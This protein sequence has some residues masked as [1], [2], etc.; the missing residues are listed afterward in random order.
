MLDKP[1]KL[2]NKST[3]KR[4]NDEMIATKPEKA[5]TP[6]SL[7]RKAEKPL[8]EDNAAGRRRSSARLKAK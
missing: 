4:E 5:K 8:P 1:V 7:K 2:S 3:P 6:V